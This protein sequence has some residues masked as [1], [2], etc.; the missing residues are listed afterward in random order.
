MEQGLID[1]NDNTKL[2]SNTAL[3][4]FMMVYHPGE[5]A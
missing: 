2:F 3:A 5:I 4:W 1:D